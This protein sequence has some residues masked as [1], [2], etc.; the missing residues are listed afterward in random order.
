MKKENELELSNGSRERV[1]YD[2]LC[3]I[4]DHTAEPHN[5]KEDFLKL[6]RACYKAT[7]GARIVKILDDEV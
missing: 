5:S 1:A 2:L 4:L 7:S 6:Y 3:L